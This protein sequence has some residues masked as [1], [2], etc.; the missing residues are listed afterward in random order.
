MT[1]L[2][3]LLN[4]LSAAWA[5]AGEL[6]TAGAI[7][8]ALNSLANLIRLTFKAGQLTGQ[9]LWPLI[10]ATSRGLHWAARNIDWRLVATIVLEGLVILAAG[11]YYLL[12]NSRRQL[13]KASAALG[14][15]Y[16]AFLTQQQQ[17]QQ[18]KTVQPLIHPLAS[19]ATEL[20]SLTVKQLRTM[21]GTRQKLRKAE[22]I[23][24]AIA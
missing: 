24:L 8:W 19:I 22:L 6:L 2:L 3:H 1:N 16:A 14:R 11:S 21:T 13:I 17:Q 20:E 4:L 18:I 5:T 10:H 9:L 15:I 12:R 7:L 23:A